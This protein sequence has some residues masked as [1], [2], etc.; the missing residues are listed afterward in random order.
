MSK[1]DPISQ[2]QKLEEKIKEMERKKQEYIEK[3]EKEIGKFLMKEW[4]IED[5]KQAKDIIT[6]LKKNVDEI[7][8]NN[9][10]DTSKHKVLNDK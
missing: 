10:R 1:R 9:S 3:A 7:F 4:E 8:N 6:Q 2:A 5:I